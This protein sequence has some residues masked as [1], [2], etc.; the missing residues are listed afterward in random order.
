M[1]S[2]STPVARV[3]RFNDFYTRYSS[4][5]SS[6]RSNT[7]SSLTSSAASSTRP[8]SD[9]QYVPL[10][11][12]RQLE[13]EQRERERMLGLSSIV[14]TTRFVE[15]RSERLKGPCDNNNVFYHPLDKM[16]TAL[17]LLLEKVFGSSSCSFLSLCI[18]QISVILIRI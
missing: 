4:L 10:S 17:T 11:R 7:S 2:V 1:C 14:T 16:L 12:R 13:R 8:T 5:L 15:T 9:Q 6:N 3:V 18:V